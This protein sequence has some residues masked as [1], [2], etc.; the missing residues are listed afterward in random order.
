MAKSTSSQQRPA[1]EPPAAEKWRLLPRE[2]GAYAQVVFPLLTALALGHGGAAP[3]Y[4]AVAAFAVFVA[5]E[6]LLILAGERGRRSHADLGEHARRLAGSLSIAALLAGILGW[7][8]AP[9]SARLALALPL[10]LAILLLPLIIRRREKTLLGELLV[11]LTFATMLIPVALAGAV[12]LYAALIASAVW[13]AIFLLATI[14]VRAVIANLKKASHSRWP[15][16]A[17]ISLSLAAIL[18]SFIL[19]LTDAMPPL[20]A[21]ATVPAALITFACSLMRIHPRRLRTLGWSLVASNVISLA[22]LVIALR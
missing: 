20:A 17:S 7:W 5:H 13:S 19:L 22:A 6:P 3:F 4:W 2:H 12:S 9:N 21:A 11:S 14:T 15:V 16:T 8:Y 1:S 18:V 10:G